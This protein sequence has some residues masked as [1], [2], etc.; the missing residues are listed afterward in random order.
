MTQSD[1]VEY[2]QKLQMDLRTKLYADQSPSS[3]KAVKDHYD[4]TV[5]ELVRL[6]G[7]NVPCWEVDCDL[8]S[9]FSDYYKDTNGFRPKERL[10]VEEVQTWIKHQS[11]RTEGV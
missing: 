6:L 4:H 2:M 5:Q 1:M 10:T 7:N 9:Y 3:V 8:W 11:E